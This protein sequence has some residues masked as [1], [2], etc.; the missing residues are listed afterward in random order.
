MPDRMEQ[1][2]CPKCEHWWM[3]RMSHGCRLD[4]HRKTNTTYELGSE[5]AAGPCSDFSPKTIESDRLEFV[6]KFCERCIQMTNH[7]GNACQKCKQ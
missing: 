4:E 6:L 7:V 2:N 5:R 1:R 3:T